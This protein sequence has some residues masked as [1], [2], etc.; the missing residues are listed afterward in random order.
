MGD[1]AGASVGKLPGRRMRSK[2]IADWI[3]ERAWKRLPEPHTG[4]IKKRAPAEKLFAAKTGTAATSATANNR[5]RPRGLTPPDA[6]SIR[7][8]RSNPLTENPMT[9]TTPFPEPATSWRPIGLLV[10]SLLA[11]AFLHAQNANP[12]DPATLARYDANRNGRLDPDEL[13][14][15]QAE[16]T[17]A[18]QTPVQDAS[19]QAGAGEGNPIVLS[20][21]QVDA[22]QD[23][24]YYASN[25]LAG[26]R[27]NSR[28]E[29]L[30]A[31][32]TIVTKQQMIDT[33]AL[34]INDVF[35][36]E[37]NTEGIFDYTASNAAS[38][39]TDPVQTNPATANRI[40]GIGT[41]NFTTDYFSH[42]AR[43]PIDAYNVGSIEITRGPNSALAGLGSPAGTVNTNLNQAMLRRDITQTQFRVDNL[44]AYRASLDF[45]R[46]IIRDRLAIRVD[47]LYWNNEYPQKPSYDLTRRIYGTI[48]YQ[49]FKNTTFRVKAES[50]REQRQTPNALTPRDAVSEWVAAGRPTWNPLTFRATVN[51][52]QTAPI[53]VGSGAT[54]ELN[55]L[56]AGLYVSNTTYT[57]PSMFIDQ[58]QVQLWEVNRLG[59]TNN[60]NSATTSNVRLLSSGTA[61]MRG[62]VN[63]GVLYQAPGVSDQ[64]LYDW[65]EINAVPTNWNRDKAGLYTVELEQRLLPNLFL[66]GAWHLE[67]SDSYNRNISN[68]PVLQID[69]NE[70]LLDGRPNPYFL[71]PFIQNIE[72]T[73]FRNPEYNDNVQAQLAY[74]LDL[75]KRQGWMHWLGR[76]QISGYYEGRRITTGTYRYREAVVDPNHVWNTPGALNYTNG[77]AVGRPTYRYYV[78][79]RGALGYTEGYA[80]PQSG[81]EGTF[82][83][84]W[85]NATTNSWVSEP[86]AFG[87]APYITSQ[88]RQEITSRGFVDQ[89][90]FLDGR[91]VFTGGIRK[92][93]NRTR[94]SNGAVVNPNTGFFEYGPLETWGS[95]TEARGTTRLVSVVGKPLRWLGL[96]YNRSSAFLPQPSAVNLFGETLPNTYG[97]TE[98]YG[99]FVNLLDQKLILTFKNYKTVQTNARTANTTLGSRIARLEAGT[100][101]D[102]SLLTFATTAATASLGANATPEQ[103]NTFVANMTQFP[104]GFAAANAA[105]LTFA[106][107]QDLESKGNE[108]ELTYNPTPRWNVKLAAAETRTVNTSIEADIQSYI[109]LRMPFWLGVRDAA[110]QSWWT[111]N[112]NAAQNFF[113]GN[114]SAPLQVDQALLGKSNPQVKRYSWRVIS[115]YQFGRDRGWL[116]NFAV[117]GSAAWNSRSVI[118]YL[119]AA[120]DPDNIVRS[121]DVNRPIYDPARATFDFWTSYTTKL[122]RDR[123]SAKFQLNLQNAFEGG[124]L[125]ATA[126]NPNGVV[127]NYRIIN[128]R[129]LVLTTTFDF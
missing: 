58:G 111:A 44:G 55:T 34:D 90:S 80:P 63:G 48:T 27:I 5:H 61:I 70:F 121:L 118:G 92:D 26:T 71:R 19:N 95:W 107:T 60:P 6:R 24:G 91:L 40:R 36:Y 42:T 3:V 69:V 68:P 84:N 112:G 110:G 104:A 17:R 22:S 74:D 122:F 16:Q 4:Q 127:Y 129:R 93:F 67:D 108:I 98:E 43:I 72:P 65:T 23:S 46:P 41:P 85:F 1:T 14:A 88:S 100:G 29:D 7:R 106:G 33:A 20:P 82:N 102:P 125:R 30:G 116:S 38:P 97:R 75:T 47:A 31:S 53:P 87:T 64:S 99:F 94:N 126:V 77:P 124:G 115:N 59:T 101:S 114:I 51:G 66:R 50:Y 113:T 2:L 62:N 21:F 32:I 86:A 28:V 56:P 54:G 49:P 13:S 109:N 79:P 78:G 128:P 103:I 117:G 89:S 35:R 120:P 18:A 45:N 52:V 119:G 105:G 15:M 37:A 9:K 123:V 73:I 8:S 81:V 11:P 96:S 57:R 83:L 12:T 25:T 39:T 76:H 10:L